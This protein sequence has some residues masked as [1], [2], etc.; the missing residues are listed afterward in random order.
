MVAY[1]L[2]FSDA[3]RDCCCEPGESTNKSLDL[4]LGQSN[5]KE[6]ILCGTK[7]RCHRNWRKEGDSPKR[8]GEERRYLGYDVVVEIKRV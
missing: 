4:K 1:S 7:Q 6:N 2:G 3:D 8:T 5:L